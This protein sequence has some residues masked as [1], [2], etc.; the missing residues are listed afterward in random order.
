MLY[1]TELRVRYLDQCS[2]GRQ[3][4]QRPHPAARGPEPPIHALAVRPL[5]LASWYI[6]VFFTPSV[7]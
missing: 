4:G 3:N 6:W 7:S 2:V 1:P 5:G